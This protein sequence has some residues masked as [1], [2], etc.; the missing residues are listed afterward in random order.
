MEFLWASVAQQASG[1]AVARIVGG[2]GCTEALIF[3]ETKPLLGR[4]NKYNEGL[5]KFW[6]GHGPGRPQR[7]SAPVSEHNT[8]KYINLSSSSQS[9]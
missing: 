9:L 8:G 1:G 3:S 5:S 6:A 7:S 4:P 2:P